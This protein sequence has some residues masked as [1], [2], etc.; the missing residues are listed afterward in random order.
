MLIQVLID[1][2]HAIVTGILNLIP[3]VTLA[4]IPY[5]GDTIQSTLLSFVLNVNGFI[6]IFPYACIVWNLFIYGVIPFE[7]AMIGLKFFL[8]SRTPSNY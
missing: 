6:D 4:S 7:L 1:L 5:I 2:E 8:G 3:S